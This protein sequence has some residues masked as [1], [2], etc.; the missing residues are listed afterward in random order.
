MERTKGAFTLL[1]ERFVLLGSRVRAWQRPADGNGAKA[2]EILDQ[3]PRPVRGDD[4][5]S[6]TVPTPHW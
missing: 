5:D 4:G 1:L 6:P 2:R 3:P